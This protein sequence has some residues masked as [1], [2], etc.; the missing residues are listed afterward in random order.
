M[1][2]YRIMTAAAIV[3]LT[4]VANAT[5]AHGDIV[6]PVT[7]WVVHNG[8][9]TVS[10]GGTNSPTFTAADN[11]TVMGTF[12]GVN[13]AN[14][15]DFAKLTTTLTLGTRTANTGVNGLRTQLRIGLFDGP[16]GVVV[17][18]DIPN[19]GFIIEYENMAAGGLIRE[20][21]SLTQTNPFTSP[22]NIGNGVQDAGGDSIQGA[23]PGPVVFELTLTLNA[24]KID[25][26]GKIS[27][28][29]SVSLNPYL[30]TYSRLGYTPVGFVYDRVGFF[31]GGNVDAPNGTLNE[32]LVTTGNVFA[33]PES[34][35][36]MLTVALMMG[37]VMTGL[38]VRRAW[39]RRGQPQP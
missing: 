5:L 15:G 13:L 12:T 2:M 1:A 26:T 14:N 30:S 27:G 28:T 23:D 7:G 17:A 32:V 9:S 11:I 16:A 39:Q 38:K 29:D 21:Q 8:T 36:G 35:F 19:T 20:Q 3:A 34:R 10:A 33:I 6:A 31:F 37:A 24:G 22:V 18:N 4:I 25:L